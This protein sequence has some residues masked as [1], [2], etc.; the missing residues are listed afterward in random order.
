MLPPSLSFP[1]VPAAEVGLTFFSAFE[2]AFLNAS[3]VLG[4]DLLK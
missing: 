4:P 2:E 3:I 1:P